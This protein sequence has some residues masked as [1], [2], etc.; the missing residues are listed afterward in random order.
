MKQ[1]FGH[2]FEMGLRQEMP[3]SLELAQELEDSDDEEFLQEKIGVLLRSIEEDTGYS[4]ESDV[5]KFYNDMKRENCLVRVER[6]SRVLET[7]EMEQPLTIS[8]EDES[9]YANAVIP[10][11]EG[12]KIAL[13]E[14]QAPGPIRIVV[15]FGKTIIGFKSDHLKVDE[16]DFS[17][18]DTRD[19]QERRYL[20]RHVT[21]ELDKDD[22]R[23]LII[24]IPSHL[25]SEDLMTE[26][27][28]KRRLPFIFRGMKLS[29]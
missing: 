28:K 26:T 16:I 17:E 1:G 27:E 23:Y 10:E 18:T 6:L 11:T 13:S 5:G 7:V 9:H 20:C 25:V 12:I 3:H 15:G 22:I 8:D 29:D 14:G 24:R 19:A 21:G 4:F 2:S